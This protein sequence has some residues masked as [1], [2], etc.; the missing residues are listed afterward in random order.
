MTVERRIRMCLLIEKI[1]EQKK[2]S[3]KLGIENKT[4][5][6]GELVNGKE[7]EKNVDHII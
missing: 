3:E 7:G 2:F 1:A 6:R 4:T 5:F